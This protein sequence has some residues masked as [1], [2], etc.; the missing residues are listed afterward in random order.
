LAQPAHGARKCESREPAHFSFALD[1][2]HAADH[3]RAMQ[4]R[5]DVR[6]VVA[7]RDHDLAALHDHAMHR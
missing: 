4:R 2:H 5:I 1:L 3:L 7:A 6:R